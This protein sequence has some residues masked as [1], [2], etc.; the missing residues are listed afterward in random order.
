MEFA[1]DTVDKATGHGRQVTRDASSVG[2]GSDDEDK[3]YLVMIVLEV[4]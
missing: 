3:W 2:M 1:S 4:G